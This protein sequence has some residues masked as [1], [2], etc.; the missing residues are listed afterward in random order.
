MNRPSPSEAEPPVCATGLWRLSRHPNLFGE[1]L[2]HAGL[3][4]LV[5]RVMPLPVLIAPAAL[6]YWTAL[7]AA[8]PRA[9][10]ERQK[11]T[12]FS[13]YSRYIDYAHSTSPFV[14]MPPALYQRLLTA[15]R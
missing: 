7:S 9:S 13:A 5:A 3:A 6:V 1:A 12:L 2:F 14:P 15:T 11:E 8:G 10:L 4:V